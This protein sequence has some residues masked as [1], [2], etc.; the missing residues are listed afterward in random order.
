MMPDNAAHILSELVTRVAK[1]R[2]RLVSLVLLRSLALIFFSVSI[3]IMLFAWLDHR[4]HFGTGARCVALVIL[5]AI[6]VGLLLAFF[7]R[8][9]INLGLE[10][11]ASHIESVRHYQ[12]Q[13]LAAVEYY[14]QQANY[15]Y[16]EPLARRMVRQFWVE[17]KDD[18][19]STTVPAWK[20]WLCAAVITVGLVLTGLFAWNHY[21][22]LARYAARLGRPTAALEPLPATRLKSLSGD[23]IA[24]PNETV[25]LQ[26]AIEGRLPQTG[27]LVIETQAKAQRQTKAETS[28]PLIEPAYDPFKALILQPVEGAVDEDPM[29]K[30]KC[31][32]EDTGIYRY[33][34]TAAGAESQWH[35]IRVCVLPEIER[36][37][38]RI[39][40]DA[41]VRQLT[42]TETVTDFVLSALAGSTAEIT[43]EASCSLESAQVKHL[44]D[45]T[46][47]YAVNGS[48]RFT[49]VTSLDREG[50]IEFRLQD[51]EGLWSRELPP[52]TVKITE[53]KRPQFSLLHPDG[54][55][56]ATNVASV[57]IRFE[58]KDDFGIADATLFLE[59]GDGRSER[60]PAAI[61][62]DTR[63][64]KVDH[65][66]ELERYDLDVGDAILFYASATDVTTGP[67]PHP[68]PAKSDVMI[69]EIKPYRRK[70]VQC[71]DT[72]PCPG[73]QMQ[74]RDQALVHDRLI[75]ILEYTRAFLKKTWRLANQ[76][77]PD[78]SDRTKQVAIA[79]DI[80]YAAEN[81]ELIRDDPRYGFDGTDIE[82][83]NGVLDDFELAR[84]ELLANRVENA[85]PPETRAYRALRRLVDDM[86]QGD[87][88]GGGS[89]P[90]DKPDKIEI[91]DVQHLTRLERARVEWQLKTLYHRLAEVAKGQEKLNRTFLHFLNDQPKQERRA[92]VNDERSW[93]T[94]SPPSV[95]DGRTAQGS[96][97]RG[98]RQD[99]TVEGALPAAT[100]AASG[101]MP[102]NFTEIM[103]V[104]RAQQKQ[105]RAELS[106]L[107]EQLARMPTGP[108]QDGNR[109]SPVEARKAARA[110]M[111]QAKRAMDRFEAF[112]AEQY[113]DRHDPEQLAR[114]AP[115]ML[116]AINSELRMAK[117][118]I[119]QEASSYAEDDMERLRQMALHLE[120]MAN[121]YDKS[122][123]PEQRRQ[124][125][126]DLAA[127]TAQLNSMSSFGAPVNAGVAGD[128]SGRPFGAVSAIK[129]GGDGDIVEA[130]RF[131]ARHFL[132]KDMEVTKRATSRVRMTS[133][134]SLR[135]YDQENDFFERAAKSRPE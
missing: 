81:L 120:D 106:T 67:T 38:A 92:Q 42:S 9:F 39:S 59:F 46:Y 118:A 102:A 56:L 130:A 134:G 83:I 111:D 75:E 121:A 72:P 100:G 37:T 86:I 48:D 1:V 50:L 94:D 91:K 110:H 89:T 90:K 128:R 4:T 124:I 24:E 96:G 2:K 20:L 27:K 79:D 47:P 133:G 28:E 126:N 18:D 40:F 30:G 109:L 15:P 23:I 71:P 61:S 113:Y 82:V 122:V 45:R 29:F 135:F 112:L 129:G 123:T 74:Q 107:E 64:A 43:V 26:A 88:K 99:R 55:C 58:I 5:V 49:F 66:L 119:Q 3:Y 25:V 117:Q 103:K 63:T 62:D 31:R 116:S 78:E 70:W 97:G 41:G 125:L 108:D 131:A 10:H 127:A 76:D 34:F 22:Y 93:V 8:M 87:P 52:L 95:Q 7:R 54:D 115:A 35:T 77:R 21:A 69:L 114:E 44:D 57:P 11:A 14:Q 19:F 65:V 132:S 6:T 101:F 12:Q 51:T 73:R 16:S 17:A 33:R 68:Q 84:N 80:E 53:D 98:P 13:L 36:I 85:I 32:F 60:I 104:L 105:L